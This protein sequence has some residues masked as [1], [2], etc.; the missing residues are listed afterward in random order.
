MKSPDFYT[1]SIGYLLHE[2]LGVH[3]IAKC[4]S[5]EEDPNYDEVSLYRDKIEAI[6]KKHSIALIIDLHGAKFDRPFCIDIGT[7]DGKTASKETI[8]SFHEA[9]R[10]NSPIEFQI[11][12][13]H[14]FKALNPS[15]VTHDIYNRC[16]I[17]TMQVEINKKYRIPQEDF[18]SFVTVLRNLTR[19]IQIQTISKVE[20]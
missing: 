3:F 18:E 15:T 10:T 17:E 9:F 16:G 19:F 4:C 6:V 11:V 1:G 13:N 14:T 8:T 5:R 7:A 20:V 12:E 2:Y